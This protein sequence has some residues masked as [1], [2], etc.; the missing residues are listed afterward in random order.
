[1]GKKKKNRSQE[2]KEVLEQLEKESQDE[3]WD[4][5]KNGRGTIKEMKKKDLC[6]FCGL[7]LKIEIFIFGKLISCPSLKCKYVK[8]V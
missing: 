1:L 5:L 8:K 2:F 3:V 6:P 4:K 7:E